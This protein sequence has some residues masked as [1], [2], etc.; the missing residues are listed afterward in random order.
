MAFSILLLKM[1]PS[2]TPQLVFLSPHCFQYYYSPISYQNF[3]PLR[4][5]LQY[6]TTFLV[7]SSK[8]LHI[9]PNVIQFSSLQQK[10]IPLQQ[11][12]YQLLF[13]AVKNTPPPSQCVTQKE[14]CLGVQFQSKRLSWWPRHGN[15]QLE[16]QIEI[17]HLHPYTERT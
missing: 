5:C 2:E 14:L 7:Q 17:S 12:L 6:S 9:S 10:S 4:L 11:L 8:V 1:S 16:Q 15:M 3:L 13:V